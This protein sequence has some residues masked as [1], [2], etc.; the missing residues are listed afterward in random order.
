MFFRMLFLF[1]SRVFLI[2]ATLAIVWFLQYESY[3]FI[4]RVFSFF[5]Q[6]S[7][8]IDVKTRSPKIIK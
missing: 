1:S 5:R 8:K 4:F 3:F 6:K 2:V 7:R